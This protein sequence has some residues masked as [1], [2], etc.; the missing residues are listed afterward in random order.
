MFVWL[1]HFGILDHNT[2]KSMISLLFYLEAQ[3]RRKPV[4]GLTSNVSES[5]RIDFLALGF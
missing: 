2:M 3:N 4:L 1:R 5:L